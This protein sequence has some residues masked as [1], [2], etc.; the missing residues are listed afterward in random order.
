MP[1]SS[2]YS[3]QDFGVYTRCG[4]MRFHKRRAIQ[5]PI[6]TRW[7]PKIEI[8]FNEQTSNSRLGNEDDGSSACSVIGLYR[9]LNG[10]ASIIKAQVVDIAIYPIPKMPLISV[11]RERTQP[12]F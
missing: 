6:L 5:I 4:A 8:P 10:E 7:R 12:C 11:Q 1:T 2:S 3:L 9:G